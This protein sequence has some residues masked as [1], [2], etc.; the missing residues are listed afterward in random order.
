MVLVAAFALQQ[1]CG[2]VVLGDEQVGGAV[3]V[4]VSGDD[5]TWVF[6]LNFVEANVGGD[7]FES[8]GAEVAE[9][10][11]FAFAVFRFAHGDEVN[12]AV[13]VVVESGDAEGASPARCR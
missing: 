6:E 8:I 13:I 9:E 12:P 4:K 2:A 1:D 7:V 10:T 3:V 5:G 11:D